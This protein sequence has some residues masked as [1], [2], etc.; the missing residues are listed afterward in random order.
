MSWYTILDNTIPN[1]VPMR[2]KTCDVIWK[3]QFLLVAHIAWYINALLARIITITQIAEHRM[4]E[5]LFNS[6][7]V[8]I[9]TWACKINLKLAEGHFGAYYVLSKACLPYF[10]TMV[11]QYFWPFVCS[12]TADVKQIGRILQKNAAKHK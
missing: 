11:F 8:E 6:K 10:S 7:A 3:L 12:P 2:Y 5:T 1:Q 4:Y 9:I